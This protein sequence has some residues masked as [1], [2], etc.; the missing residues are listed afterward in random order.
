MASPSHSDMGKVTRD[1]M[2][3]LIEAQAR[4]WEAGDSDAI[5]DAFAEDGRLIAP[6]LILTGPEEVREGAA[7]YFR[8]YRNV[9]IRICSLLSDGD[10][11][12]VEWTWTET[13]R[14]TDEVLVTDDAILVRLRG[15][16]IVY[17]REYFDG[18]GR[19]ICANS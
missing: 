12:A 3:A 1:E 10:A 6:G 14:D 4:C 18:P 9:R 7:D 2:R 5:A 8:R 17:W 19:G 16:K 11:A 15:G 13:R